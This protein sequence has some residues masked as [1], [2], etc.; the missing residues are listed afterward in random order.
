MSVRVNKREESKVE[1]IR[2]ARELIKHTFM[3]TRRKF[4]NLDRNKIHRLED[5]VIEISTLINEANS[6]YST[7]ENDNVEIKELYKK[8]RRKLYALSSLLSVYQEILDNRVKEYG[9]EK[10]GT[11]I[12]LEIGLLSGLIKK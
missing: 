11:L 2:V 9:W 5:L 6:I 4:N 3:Q 8:A 12:N 7:S 1:F 10:W